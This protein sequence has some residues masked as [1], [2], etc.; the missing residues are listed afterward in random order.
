MKNEKYQLF[1]SWSQLSNINYYNIYLTAVNYN[2]KNCCQFK[3]FFAAKS[4]TWI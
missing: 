1:L 2:I 4:K 3:V